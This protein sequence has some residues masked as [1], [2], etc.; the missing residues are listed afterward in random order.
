MA[1]SVLSFSTMPGTPELNSR[2]L[3]YAPRLR[4]TG[5]Y[6]V[7][8]LEAASGLSQMDCNSATSADKLVLC[9]FSQQIFH[10]LGY[11]D[12]NTAILKK[13]WRV[14]VRIEY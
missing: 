7:V 1:A 9:H 10:A 14:A 13:K 4:C 6:C 8:R 5:I 12:K 3:Q 11:P 2:L